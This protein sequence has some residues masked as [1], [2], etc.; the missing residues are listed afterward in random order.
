MLPSQ[1]D[2]RSTLAFLIWTAFSAVAIVPV[3][4]LANSAALE[5]WSREL[6]ADSDRLLLVTMI[7]V[8]AALVAWL[9]MATGWLER[10]YASIHAV[11]LTTTAERSQPTRV[12]RQ[13]IPGSTVAE[14]MSVAYERRSARSLSVLL[15]A[16]ALSSVVV[17]IDSSPTT[18][19]TACAMG[20]LYVLAALRQALL[21]IRVA[22]RY[23]GN[24]EHEVR[25]LLWFVLLHSHPNDFS[26][27]GHISTAINVTT[28][29]TPETLDAAEAT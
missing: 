21:R 2:I 26:T 11:A 17:W 25:Q 28:E 4:A 14:M 18:L 20:G 23:F 5:Q 10:F 12:L 22:K 13:R 9:A 16:F 27:G 15:I 7:P 19:V 24:T 3:L 29:K 8:A 6:M 1:R